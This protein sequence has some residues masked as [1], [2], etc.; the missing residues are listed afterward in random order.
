MDWTAFRQTKEVNQKSLYYGVERAEHSEDFNDYYL[1]EEGESVLFLQGLTQD[2]SFIQFNISVAEEGMY[3]LNFHTF[4]IG[5]DKVNRVIVNGVET[6]EVHST[7]EKFSDSYARFIYLDRGNHSIRLE[8]HWGYIAVK[9]LEVMK[10]KPV[11]QSIYDVKPNLIN[12]YA[13]DEAKRL[14]K[15]LTDQYG[16]TILSGQSS[17]EGHLGKEFQAIAKETGGKIPAILGLDFIDESAS[18]RERLSPPNVL[19]HAKTFH[20]MGGLITFMWHWNAPEKYLYDSSEHPWWSGFYTEH[21]FIDLDAIMNGEDPEGYELLIKEMDEIA[22]QLKVLRD[23]NIPVLWRPLHEASGG[24]FWWGDSGPDPFIKLWQVMYERYVTVH[25]LHNLIWVWNGQGKDWYPGDRY[26]DIIGEDIYA[27]KHTYT[28]QSDRFATAM[29]YT[30]M[31]K[32]IVLSENGVL[33]DP[34]LL[35]RDNVMWGYFTTWND[36]FV[37]D[38]EGNYSEEYTETK[39]LKKVYT[40]EKVLTLDDLPDLTNYSGE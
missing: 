25:G 32:L 13:T 20:D 6:A 31:D 23:E 30:S 21:T 27:A 24:W 1:H 3:D 12:P 11:D 39:M 2:D 7:A 4:G 26:V 14:M 9:G 18:R 5:G 19:D 22:E 40:H 28:S 35:I 16:N 34:D 10:T 36:E 17:N 29:D 8:K 15:F 33:P 38:N 37:V